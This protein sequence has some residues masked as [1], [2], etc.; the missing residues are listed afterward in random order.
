MNSSLPKISIIIAHFNTEITIKLCLKSCLSQDYLNK[1]IIVVDGKSTDKTIK[2][3]KEF[4][5]PNL[6][7]FQNPTM[8]YMMHGIMRSKLVKVIGFVLLR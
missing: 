5:K 8:A 2:I 4:N 1:E 7:F 6:F 3:V